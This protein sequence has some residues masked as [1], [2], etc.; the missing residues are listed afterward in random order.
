MSIMQIV[1][2]FPLNAVL[3]P[4][5]PLHLH[6]FE[7]RY[8][9]MM[10]LCLEERRPFGVVLIRKGLEA[11]GPLAEPHRVGCTASI[12]DV[13]PLPDGRINLT[14][15]GE[16]R[17]RV[18][19][20][21]TTSA[22]YLLGDVEMIPM[23]KADTTEAGET[24]LRLKP[25]VRRYL[26]VQGDQGATPIETVELPDDPESLGYLAAALLQEPLVKKQA[27]LEAEDNLTLLRLL[28]PAYR[29]ETALLQ[30]MLKEGAS[31]QEGFS[32]N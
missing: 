7:E 21:H 16:E 12:V 23:P 5:M 13:Q 20:L 11:M 17:F 9:A 18:V 19:E 27:Y 14:A 22:S 31:K 2:L 15:V 6:I 4:G 28:L 32:R 1:P 25:W 26:D 24:A 8:K 10:R 3:F 30:V 29:R